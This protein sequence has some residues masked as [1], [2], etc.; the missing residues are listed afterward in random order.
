[1][2]NLVFVPVVFVVIVSM[3]GCDMPERIARLEKQTSELKA[4]LDRQHAAADLDPQAKCSRDA[5]A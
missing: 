1:M 2:R 4:E 3:S 5:K